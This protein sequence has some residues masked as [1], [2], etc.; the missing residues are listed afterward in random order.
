MFGKEKSVKRFVVKSSQYSDGGTIMI[1]VDK[2]TGVNYLS[3]SGVG[4][5]SITPL[6]DQDGNVTIDK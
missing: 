6:L 1:L 5:S 3:I 4:G 2:K